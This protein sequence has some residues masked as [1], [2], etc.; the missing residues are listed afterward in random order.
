MQIESIYANEIEQPR[1]YFAN[2]KETVIGHLPYALRLNIILP[3]FQSNFSSPDR[4]KADCVYRRNARQ[5]H[6]FVPDENL[7]NMRFNR[8]R[9]II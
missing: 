1:K 4:P 9:K 6:T 5:Q 3:F 2:N 7:N 8:N